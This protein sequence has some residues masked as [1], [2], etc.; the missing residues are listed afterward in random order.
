MLPLTAT[1]PSR[2][3]ATSQALLLP[4]EHS[5]G[6]LRITL[7]CLPQPVPVGTSG[8]PKDRLL[9]PGSIPLST[10]ACKPW[11]WGSPSLGSPLLAPKH[12]SQSL[13]LNLFNLPLPPQLATNH[14]CLLQAWGNGLSQLLPTPAQTAWVLKVILPRLMPSSTPCPV[15]RGLKTCQPV[16]LTCAIPGTQARYLEAQE[17]AYLNLLTLVPAYTALKPKDRQFQPTGAT[18]GV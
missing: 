15:R 2:S 10:Q 8:E 9:Q 13:R 4:P 5:D 3:K 11:A 16:W 18:T 17:L 6:S 1:P 14:K 12:S 7:P